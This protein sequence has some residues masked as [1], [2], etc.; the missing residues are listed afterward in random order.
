MFVSYPHP[1]TEGRVVTLLT[2]MD[3]DRDD[4]RTVMVNGEQVTTL[5][6]VV[7]NVM[8]KKLPPE[9]DRPVLKGGDVDYGVIFMLTSNDWHP[10]IGNSSE[11]GPYRLHRHI[12]ALQCLVDGDIPKLIQIYSGFIH[13]TKETISY[14]LRNDMVG[15]F[16]ADESLIF[17]NYASQAKWQRAIHLHTGGHNTVHVPLFA[18]PISPAR[19]MGDGHFDRPTPLLN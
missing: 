8:N 15:G 3:D 18:T 9:L 2:S 6:E 10:E 14:M 7:L 1:D 13:D 19:L 17:Q 16:D 5:S 11:V 4:V 12:D